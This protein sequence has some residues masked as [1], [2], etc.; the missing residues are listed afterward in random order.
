MSNFEIVFLAM[1]DMEDATLEQVT[2]MRR[3]IEDRQKEV[4]MLKS[5]ITSLEGEIEHGE[6]RRTEQLNKILE[7]E[8]DK[9]LSTQERSALE[10]DYKER[11]RRCEILDEKA[12]N[13]DDEN[14]KYIE[15]IREL[16]QKN[17]AIEKE[18]F[19]EGQS[20]L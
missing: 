15:Q 10:R 19:D 12:K 16:N 1:V 2:E 18:K 17:R 3:Q 6:E 8:N 9:R 7:L 20:V 14:A 11:E 4:A 13:L 5:K